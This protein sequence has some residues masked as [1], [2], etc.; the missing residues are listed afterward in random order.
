[1]KTM[2]R[3][4]I[5]RSKTLVE[6][7]G[8]GHNRW[9]PDIPPVIRCDRGDE[10]ILDTRDAFDRQMG[11]DAVL[12]RHLLAERDTLPGTWRD[13]CLGIAAASAGRTRPNSNK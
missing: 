9:H 8:P 13:E 6:E 4:P 1:M 5:D 11:P 10:V 3:S 12:V 2:P 7:P